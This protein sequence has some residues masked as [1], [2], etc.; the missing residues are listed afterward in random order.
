MQA[1][2]LNIYF[3]SKLRV[4]FRGI[5]ASEIAEPARFYRDEVKLILDFYIFRRER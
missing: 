4:F 1:K 5:S 2:K 3:D